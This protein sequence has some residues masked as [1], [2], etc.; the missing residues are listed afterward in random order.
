[1]Y[2]YLCESEEER[3][4]G[5]QRKLSSGE[6]VRLRRAAAPSASGERGKQSAQR[7]IMMGLHHAKIFFLVEILGLL[8]YYVV[9]LC[10]E[11]FH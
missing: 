2:R 7:C 6:S 10:S 5:E 4:R 3:E 8:I 1:M 9:L 11:D